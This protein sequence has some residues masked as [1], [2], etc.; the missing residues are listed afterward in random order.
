[1]AKKITPPRGMT[2]MESA[3]DCIN[4]V[5]SQTDTIAIALSLGKDSIVTLDL[6][7]PRFNR[8]VCF[9]MYWV[10]GLTH[11]Q[12][13]IDWVKAKYPRIEFVEIPHWNLSY[14]LRSGLYCTPQ[15]KVKLI[16]LADV[17]ET[18][19][20]TY[21]VQY[22]ALGMKKA[23]GMNRL[24]MIKRFEEQHY[25]NNNLV[26]PLADWNQ[27]DILAYMKQRHLPEPVR[28]GKKASSSLGFSADCFKWMYKY[29]PEDLIKVYDVFPLARRILFEEMNKNGGTLN[30][31]DV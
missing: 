6:C 13:W 2:K 17:C 1:M 23:D 12:R 22:I 30:L 26:Y 31:D 3:L 25:V 21:N 15:P 20:V 11:I 27:K 14:L 4:S 7:Y 19:R 24:L 29:F 8:I 28:Y 10:K 18:I 16:K 5:R 9:F